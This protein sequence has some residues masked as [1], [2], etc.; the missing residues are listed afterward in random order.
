MERSFADRVKGKWLI[1]GS[2]NA[3]DYYMAIGVNM[4]MASFA[5][6]LKANVEL[7]LIPDGFNLTTSTAVKTV[8]QTFSFTDTTTI[9]N[10][11]TSGYEDIVCKVHKT[12][13]DFTHSH[14]G[15]L[16]I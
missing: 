10:P 11:M 6:N 7:E 13:W 9:Y 8:T 16:F 3:K 1:F 4:I 14:Q 12:S 5:A 2:R 15:L